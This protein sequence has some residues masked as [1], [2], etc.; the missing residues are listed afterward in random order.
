MS[1][2]SSYAIAMRVL[3]ILPVYIDQVSTVEF[4]NESFSNWPPLLAASVWGVAAINLVI[5]HSNDRE[6]KKE[7][8]DLKWRLEF[9][10]KNCKFI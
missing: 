6:H 7:I 10:K 9:F 3:E 4:I 5:M 2:M 8:E 1:E